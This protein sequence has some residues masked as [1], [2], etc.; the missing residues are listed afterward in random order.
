MSTEVRLNAEKRE[1]VRK[2]ANRKLRASGRVPA[3]L[4]GKDTEPALLSVDARETERLF[5]Q[6][7]VEN[8]IIELKV[9]GDRTKVQALVREVQVEALRPDLIHIDFYKIQKG[10]RLE[11]D[12]PVELSGIPNGVR[13]D[14][15]VLEQLFHEIPV[16]CLPDQIPESIEIDVTDLDLQDS[17]HVSDLAIPEGVELLMDLERTLCVVSVPR[18][19]AEPEDAEPVETEVIGDETTETPDVEEG[20]SDRGEP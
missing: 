16:R 6:I 7:S 5:Q 1:G 12:I 11:V 9:K 19:I 2:G 3:I 17:L 20:E 14:G 18:V 13:N 8:T 4:Y 15:G 10:V